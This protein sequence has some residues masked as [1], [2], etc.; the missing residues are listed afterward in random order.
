MKTPIKV[1]LIALGT[2]V[3]A[4]LLT[5]TI[6]PPNPNFGAPEA[7]LMPY[8]LLMAVAETLFFGIGVAFLA[9]GLPLMRRVASISGLSPWPVYLS[10]GYLTA[11]WWPHLGM[12]AVAGMNFELLIIVDYVFHLPYILSAG[13]VA[14]FF[15]VT[16]QA[17]ARNAGH[18][19]SSEQPVQ[20][21]GRGQAV[22][23]A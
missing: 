14:H 17:A 22:K 12:H 8:F 7:G 6:F 11:S 21:G 2:G 16:L 9:L 20:S 23:A 10:I 4:F 3:P 18:R 15:F 1:A 5:P 13:I 19:S